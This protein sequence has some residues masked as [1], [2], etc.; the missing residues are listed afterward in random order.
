MTGTAYHAGIGLISSAWSVAGFA[1]HSV[2][3]PGSGDAGQSSLVSFRGIAGGMALSAVE[4]RL[5]SGVVRQ[6][7]IF[8]DIPQRGVV[9]VSGD[10]VAVAVEEVRF[11]VIAAHHVTDVTPTHR[12]AG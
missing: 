5:L 7:S 10:D 11:P 6:P 8:P 1:A 12:R 4:R 9:L 3:G 2:L